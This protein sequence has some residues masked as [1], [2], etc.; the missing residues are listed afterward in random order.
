M[1]SFSFRVRFS[2][3]SRVRVRIN[4]K[5]RFR[6]RVRLRSRFKV[7]FSLRASIRLTLIGRVWPS[8]RLRLR[9]RY[10]LSA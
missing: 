10:R 7:R 6:V 4:L 2:L 5:D 9:A 8:F 1:V 3:R